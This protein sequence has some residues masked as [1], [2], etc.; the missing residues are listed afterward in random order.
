MAKV[1]TKSEIQKEIVDNLQT[2][3]HGILKLAPRVGKTKLAIDIIKREAPKKILWATPNEDLKDV[4]IPG[5]F[6]TWKALTYYRKSKVVCWASLSKVK[7]HYPMIIL[8]ELQYITAANVKP[9][10]DGTVTYD[11]I[12]A[13]TGTLPKGEDKIELINKLGLKVLTSMEIDEAVD[14]E[15]IADYNITVVLT[16]LESE[17]KTVKAGSKAKPFLQTEL[18]AYQYKTKRINSFIFSKRPVPEFMYIDRLHLIRNLESKKKVAENLLR[19]L[20]GRTLIFASSIEQAESLCKHTHHSKQ[21]NS[22]NLKAFIDGK[23][24]RLACV[25]SGGVGTTYRDVD[26]FIV[27]Q[28]NSNKNGDTTQKI[29]RSLV[30]Q[31]GYKAN[32]YIIGVENTVDIGWIEKA[33]MDFSPDKVKWVSS[34]QY[35]KR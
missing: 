24:D 14:Q 13:L 11:Y 17:L 26:N 7:G 5:E 16:Q 9:L 22:D 35:E 15:M 29:A 32:I 10:L 21:K 33:L 2:K 6:K 18:A 28:A 3:P 23:I 20:P 4:A 19:V 27:V 8:D 1:K 25:N 12:V 30:P 31:E 34:R